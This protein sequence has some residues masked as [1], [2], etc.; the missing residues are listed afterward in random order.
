MEARVR[1][2]E[3]GNRWEIPLFGQAVQE[4][5]ISR[6]VALRIGM[7]EAVTVRIW[8]AFSLVHR[9]REHRLVPGEPPHEAM[10]PALG[11]LFAPVESVAAYKRDGLLL[12]AFSG[13]AELRVERGPFEAWDL[14]GPRGLRLIGMPLGRPLAIWKPKG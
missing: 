7:E 3:H 2:V 6:S 8:A 13:G 9:G 12:V 4:C 11:R 5:V 10:A 14:T 1:L